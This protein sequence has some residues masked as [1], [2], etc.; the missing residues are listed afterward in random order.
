[1]LRGDSKESLGVRRERDEC[2]VFPAA[3]AADHR[4]HL[5]LWPD[6]SARNDAGP[7]ACIRASSAAQRAQ[8]AVNRYADREISKIS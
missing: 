2:A 5:H 6:S 3:E 7:N 8:G 1:M 4:H